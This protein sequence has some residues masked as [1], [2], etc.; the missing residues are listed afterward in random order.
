MFCMGLRGGIGCVRWL[1]RFR[2]LW[3]SSQKWRFF[4]G[5]DKICRIIGL[6]TFRYIPGNR[7]NLGVL[8]P[9]SNSSG[10][11]WT[12]GRRGRELDLFWRRWNP[13]L[14]SR[15]LVGSY[16]RRGW[17]TT[18]RSRARPWCLSSLVS[19]GFLVAFFRGAPKRSSSKILRGGSRPRRGRWRGC[20]RGLAFSRWE[21][22]ITI[23]HSPKG[24]E[25]LRWSLSLECSPYV[26]NTV[27]LSLKFSKTGQ[28]CVYCR[29]RRT[30][31]R[32]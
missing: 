5:R 31:G 28:G 18:G 15:I 9:L 19:R 26:G 30:R 29:R 32:S 20:D 21:W 8:W 11:W 2:A 22:N 4:W 3:L 24:E 14:F 17:W 27:P 10:F 6:W 7:S 23:L 1:C 25:S 16:R 12:R 13:R